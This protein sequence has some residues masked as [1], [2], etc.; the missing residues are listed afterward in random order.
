[1]QKCLNP[2]SKNTVAES[3]QNKKCTKQTKQIG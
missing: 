2:E 1:M 3:S